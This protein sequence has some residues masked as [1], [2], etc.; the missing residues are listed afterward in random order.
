MRDN[1]QLRRECPATLL[2]YALTGSNIAMTEKRDA[3]R[4]TIGAP[5]RFR[6]HNDNQIAQGVVVDMS[7]TGILLESDHELELGTVINAEIHEEHNGAILR[8]SGVIVR[9]EQTGVRST[10]YGCRFE[11]AGEN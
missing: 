11:R 4:L 8:F 5:I 3:P 7:R 10:R 2:T 1:G 6:M 9:I